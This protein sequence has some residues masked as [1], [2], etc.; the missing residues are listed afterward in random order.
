MESSSPTHLFRGDKRMIYCE[1]EKGNYVDQ[2]KKCM[3]CI[4]YKRDEDSCFYP[5]WVPGLIQKEKNEE[6]NKEIS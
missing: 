4:F 5:E 6:K 3:K 2:N 1:K